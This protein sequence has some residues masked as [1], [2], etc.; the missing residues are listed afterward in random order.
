MHPSHPPIDGLGL[1]T[2]PFSP[3]E[4]V[5]PNQSFS[6]PVDIF[7]LGATLYQCI[8]GREPYRGTKTVEMMHHVRKGSLW[9]RE[10]QRRLERVGTIHEDPMGSPFPSA[11]RGDSAAGV[12]RTGSLRAE[13]K[14][15]SELRLPKKQSTD[16]MRASTDI[17][18]ADPNKPHSPAAVR[19]WVNWSNN[20]ISAPGTD[21]ISRLLA[22][23]NL[24]SPIATTP[25][26]EAYMLS[27]IFVEPTKDSHSGTADLGDLTSPHADG[28]PVMLYLDGSTRVDEAVRDVIKS[29][30]DPRAAARPTAADV[31]RK[32]IQLSG[33]DDEEELA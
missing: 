18:V 33:E 15:Y 8:T 10:E 27:P 32:L 2:L 7:S 1:G 17:I 4:L 30:V 16:S 23:E 3:P 31:Y 21:V 28:S 29:M 12:R 24:P 14:S 13:I 9:V 26:T 6:F 20:A 11:W 25:T 19:A 5:D 22:E